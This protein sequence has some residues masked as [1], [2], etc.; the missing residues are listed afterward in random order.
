VSK[1]R[2]EKDV[3]GSLLSLSEALHLYGE[4]RGFGNFLMNPMWWHRPPKLPEIF[5]LDD[6][7]TV[8]R[9]LE[10]RKRHFGG[11]T[12]EEVL[13]TE[14]EGALSMGGGWEDLLDQLYQWTPPI[15]PF[16]FFQPFM[17][18]VSG[19]RVPMFSRIGPGRYIEADNLFL[20]T[21]QKALEVL[22]DH[23]RNPEEDTPFF[24]AREPFELFEHEERQR[25]RKQGF[26][27][28]DTLLVQTILNSGDLYTGSRREFAKQMAVRFGVTANEIDSLMKS[29]VFDGFRKIRGGNAG[30][31]A[32]K[33]P[34]TKRRHS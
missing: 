28:A 12:V 34:K 11:P 6:H 15:E 2:F 33:G 1:F 5:P 4:A 29:P 20:D 7:A 13:A 14:V 32:R 25:H 22:E 26:D 19:P 3:T 27:L 23:V 18:A 16:D 30:R 21:N 31:P 9:A 8:R 24:V 10:F 17:K